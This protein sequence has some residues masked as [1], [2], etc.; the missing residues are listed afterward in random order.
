MAFDDLD[1]GVGEFEI[2]PFSRLLSPMIAGGVP[3]LA[4]AS[5]F[6]ELPVGLGKAALGAVVEE[7]GV[8]LTSEVE[9]PSDGP[10]V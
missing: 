3:E 8:L 6:V 5:A 9:V 1:A 2:R 4:G 10:S 7:R